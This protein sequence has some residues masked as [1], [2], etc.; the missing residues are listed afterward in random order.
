MK[1]FKV[2]TVI[3]VCGFMTTSCTNE[4]LDA[5]IEGAS[6]NDSSFARGGNGAP[7]G[8][9][10]NLNLIG[11]NDKTA[12]MDGNNGHRIFVK[13]TG[14]TKIWLAEGDDFQVT[15]ANGTDND[16]AAFTLPNPDPDNDGITEYS[17]F[18]RALGGPGGTSTMTTC[19]TDPISL[20]EICSTESLVSVRSKGK[21]T[22][23]NVSRELLY[24]YYDLDGDGTAERYNLFHDDLEDYFWS[25]DNNRL[26]ILQLRFYP[27]ATDVN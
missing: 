10:Y 21:S 18:A 9:H 8:A 25:Y 16:G 5:P 7:S 2:L 23:S 22:F 11:V 3:A 26:R 27:I 17:V 19:A 14:N 20:E 4:Q 15:D 24:I 1:T 13:L 12:D 6:I